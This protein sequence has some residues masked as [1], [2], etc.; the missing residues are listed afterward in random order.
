MQQRAPTDVLLRGVYAA[1]RL[2]EDPIAIAGAARVGEEAGDI[3]L[4]SVV[5]AVPRGHHLARAYKPLWRI[6]LLPDVRVA[7]DNDEE[8]LSH[9]GSAPAPRSAHRA[10][11]HSNFLLPR[12]KS[13]QA[14]AM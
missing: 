6:S 12:Q 10:L 8:G 2:K 7:T 14:A 4:P 9:F 1:V 13:A 5:I 11:A 3:L